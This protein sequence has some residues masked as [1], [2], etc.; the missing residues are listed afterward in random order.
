MPLWLRTTLRLSAVVFAT[1]I[2][3]II[4]LLVVR[5]VID[6]ES[7]KDSSDSLGTFV[8]TL[9]GIY[10]VLLAF[11]VIVVWGQFNDARTLVDR[12]AN[13]LVDLHRT[14]SGLPALSR[15]IIQTELRAYVDAVIHDEWKAMADS[16]QT[17][18]DRITARLD[19][20]WTAIHSCMPRN[21]CQQAMYAEILTRFN[22]L[23]ELRTNRL[24]SAGARIPIAMNVLLYTGALIMIG[25]VYLL[26]FDR[27]WLHAT[28]T[29]LMTGAVAHI[30]FLIRDLDDAFAGDWQVEKSP[31]MRARKAFD[32]T[33]QMHVSEP[34]AGAS[35][36]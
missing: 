30:L 4:G 25:A 18:I 24:S 32:R 31:F 10:A 3:S 23:T 11:V 27:F 16:D 36:A 7:L 15:E 6:Y 1:S 35:A 34:G 20:V 29:G 22:D 21:E 28:V 13:A 19:H 17:A 26:A 5:Q 14:A 9:G 12:E 33:A 2:V 8:Q